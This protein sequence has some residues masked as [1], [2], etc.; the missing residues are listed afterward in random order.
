L[1]VFFQLLISTSERYGPEGFRG[2][3]KGGMIMKALLGFA[4]IS[5]LVSAFGFSAPVYAGALEENLMDAIRADD[6]IKLLLS[7]GS[8]VNAK[9][10][11][12]DTA[13]IGASFAGNTDLVALLIKNGAD[14]NAANKDGVSPLFGAACEGRPDV[15]KLLLEKGA[16]VKARENR[17]DATPLIIAA[18][19]GHK[20]V[21]EMLINK[22]AEVNAKDREG[23]TALNWASS[24]G[25]TSVVA[26]LKS[27][28]AK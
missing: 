22:G 25:H 6:V 21:A 3:R 5:M 24:R 1:T 16:N 12:G 13:L 10:E 26:L 2:A 4:L 19:E 20:E 14:V 17:N 27:R 8:D 7:K 9:N 11:E 18:F 23:N 15:V 28:G